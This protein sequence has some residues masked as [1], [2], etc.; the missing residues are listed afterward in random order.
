MEQYAG[1]ILISNTFYYHF[2]KH[3]AD[4]Y[5]GLKLSSLFVPYMLID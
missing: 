1:N 2:Y 4:V 5:P 3:T